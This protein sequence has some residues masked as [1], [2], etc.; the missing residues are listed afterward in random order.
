M[1]DVAW[2]EHLLKV[3]KE[4]SIRSKAAFTKKYKAW[5]FFKKLTRVEVDLDA[6]YTLYWT[7]YKSLSRYP[8]YQS[9]FLFFSL[10][11]F[12]FYFF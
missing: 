8:G 12:S 9:L 7:C 2:E 5:Y 1:V 3:E 4:F 11:L 6:V 10:F